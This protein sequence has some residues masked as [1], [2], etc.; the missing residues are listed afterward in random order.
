MRNDPEG[1]IGWPVGK[2]YFAYARESD[3]RVTQRVFRK[4]DSAD[5]PSRMQQAR[6]IVTDAVG[7][8]AD[9]M[10]PD[11]AMRRRFL[12]IQEA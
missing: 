8:T 9:Q 11:D 10:W 2:Q 12:Q 6:A 7:R 3:S 4:D 5:W 1:R